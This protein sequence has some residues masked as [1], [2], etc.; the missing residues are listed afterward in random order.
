MQSIFAS[1]SGSLTSALAV[2]IVRL[3]VLFLP[4]WLLLLGSLLV[5][6]GQLHFL[7]WLGAVFQILF[8][9]LAFRRPREAAASSEFI[10]VIM[11]YLIALGWLWVG[12]IQVNAQGLAEWYRHL[13][14][15]ILLVVPVVIFALQTIAV[16]S[17]PALRRAYALAQGL[18][19][20][21]DW[22]AEL[23]DCRTLPE[24]K[25]FRDAVHAD[26]A[27]AIA[28]LGHSRP[29]VRVAALAAL[30]FRKNWKPG[31]AERVLRLARTAEEPVVRAA[32]VTALGNVDDRDLVESLAESLR[33]RSREVRRAAMHALLWDINK[34]W[35]WIRPAVRAA[36]ADSALQDD[37]LLWQE[38]LILTPDVRA[39]LTAWAAERGNL[40]M[41]AAQVLGAQYARSLSERHDPVL[42]AELRR[43]L[44]DG[45]S[46]SVLRLELARLLLHHEQLD[47]GFLEQLLQ[48]ANPVPLRL[49]AADALLAH[50]AHDE[51]VATLRE[52]ARVSNREIAL[53][54]A[55]V[56]QRRLGIDMGLT[57]S[58]PPPSVL[59][60]RAAEIMR[61]VMVWASGNREGP[62]DQM[63]SS[64]AIQL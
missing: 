64:P 38:E 6:A 46:P 40:A 12:E 35:A 2:H 19:E 63:S 8:C 5:P 11:L 16:S 29:Q 36:L 1:R 53:A 14:Q 52:I 50:Q 45:H 18:A 62:D 49:L 13:A 15:A 20:R 4:A 56:L 39:D 7:L 17:S 34:R 59:S 41:R 42:I 22:P 21:T 27:P 28:L 24:V 47:R 30:E 57:L 58:E 33:D 32:A 31:Q 26:G 44:A 10:L 48:A 55:Q 43:Q 25:A 3:I 54:T 37:T 9:Y 51:A 60:R 61:N 23:G